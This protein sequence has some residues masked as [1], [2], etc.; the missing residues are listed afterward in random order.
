MEAQTGNPPLA[1]GEGLRRFKVLWMMTFLTILLRAR[2]GS[3]PR[4]YTTFRSRFGGSRLALHHHLFQGWRVFAKENHRSRWQELKRGAVIL[5][6]LR[7][8]LLLQ[9]DR[10]RD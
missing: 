4:G 2:G 6:R 5:C 9:E 1:G 10:A 8:V 7:A 3:W